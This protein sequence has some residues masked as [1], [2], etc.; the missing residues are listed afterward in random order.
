MP[1][2]SNLTSLAHIKSVLDAAL[3]VGGGRYKLGSY[4]EAVRWRA[5]AY[6]YRKL[7]KEEMQNSGLPPNTPYDHMK[8]TIEDS[9]VVI[10]KHVLIGTLMDNKGETLEFVTEL[11]DPLQAQA[12]ELARQLL[13]EK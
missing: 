9:T 3:R 11:D 8:L 13:G 2:T 10:G 5:E 6:Q 12:D 1:I 7:L 4:K